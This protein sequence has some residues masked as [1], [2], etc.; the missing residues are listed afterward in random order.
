MVIIISE[1]A[2]DGDVVKMTVFFFHQACYDEEGK[3]ATH[4]LDHVGFH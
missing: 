1:F 3:K 2:S 4:G